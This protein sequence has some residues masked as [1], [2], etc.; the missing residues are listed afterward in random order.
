MGH[1]PQIDLRPNK[2]EGPGLYDHGGF[3]SRETEKATGA[4]GENGVNATTVDA[5]DAAAD[6]G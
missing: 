2:E 4:A 3:E 6:G 1:R 5:V